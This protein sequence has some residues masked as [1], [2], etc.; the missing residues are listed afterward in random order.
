MTVT[1]IARK[2]NVKPIEVIKFLQVN[3]E[4]TPYKDSILNDELLAYINSDF[5]NYHTNLLEKLEPFYSFKNGRLFREI[6]NHNK[7]EHLTLSGI[8]SPRN[9]HGFF[10]DILSNDGD[11]KSVV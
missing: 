7:V 1:E 8:Y 4:I 11:R 3:Q 2:L 5:E 9:G 6:K 10:I